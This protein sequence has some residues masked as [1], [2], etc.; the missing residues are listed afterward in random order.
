MQLD[1]W[2]MFVLVIVAA[3]A[4]MIWEVGGVKAARAR[5]SEEVK[6]GF[7]KDTVAAA[8]FVAAQGDFSANLDPWARMPWDTT[9]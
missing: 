8:A 7:D 6:E 1:G 9:R 5:A 3:M 2:V 4:L